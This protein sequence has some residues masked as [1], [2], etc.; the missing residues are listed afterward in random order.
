MRLMEER[1]AHQLPAVTRL[2]ET[3]MDGILSLSDLAQQAD[4]TMFEELRKL[5]ARD[6][7]SRGFTRRGTPPGAAASSGSDATPA[8]LES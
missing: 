2:P 7:Q 3:E 6:S 8:A 4:A 5:A 1:Q